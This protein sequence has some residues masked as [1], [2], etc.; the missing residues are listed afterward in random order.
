MLVFAVLV[1]GLLVPVVF[2]MIVWALALAMR[3]YTPEP[4]A[5]LLA[6]HDPAMRAAL[7][8]LAGTHRMSARDIRADL[9]ARERAAVPPPYEFRRDARPA[10]P[11]L[12]TVWLQDVGARCN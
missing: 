4:A 2:V 12:P 6:L 1:A 5:T 11:G 9:R 10:H 8:R 7:A 3:L